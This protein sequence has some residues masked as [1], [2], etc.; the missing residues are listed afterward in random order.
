MRALSRRGPA[1]WGGWCVVPSAIEF[2]RDGAHR[3]HDR[4]LFTRAG[5]GWSSLRL[6]P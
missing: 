5:S 2:W 4:R 3:L 1:H 6:N